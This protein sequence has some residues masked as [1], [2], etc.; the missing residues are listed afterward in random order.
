MWRAH[1]RNHVFA[2]RVNEVFAVENLFAAGRIPRKRHPRR[3]SVAHV[4]KHHRL[5][6]D[7]SSPIVGDTVLSPI[8]DRAIVHP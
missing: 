7:R 2:L 4:S 8:N 3:A 1:A 6:I 5:N